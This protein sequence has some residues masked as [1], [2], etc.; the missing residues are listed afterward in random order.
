MCSSDLCL[1]MNGREVFKFAVNRFRQVIE[2]ALEA[3]RLTPADL[4]QVICHQ[5]NVRI[6]ESAMEKIG[7]PKDKVFV[8]IDRF[9]NS[10]AG[11]V[12]LCLDQ[13]WR[14]GK[15]PAGQPMMMVAFGG[16]MTWASGVWNV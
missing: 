7:L 3:T 10:S 4:S 5:S 6:I 8:N 16:G 15:V 9:G 11:S 1:R 14:A 2:E 12:G 13:L